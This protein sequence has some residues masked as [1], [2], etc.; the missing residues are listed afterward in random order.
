MLL[1]FAMESK[2]RSGMM[3]NAEFQCD[4]FRSCTVA[5]AVKD[6]PR[7][8]YG[9]SYF[10]VSIFRIELQTLRAALEFNFRF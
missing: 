1:T 7:M 4:E 2:G 8:L 9:I 10:Y 3:R 5:F 6:S